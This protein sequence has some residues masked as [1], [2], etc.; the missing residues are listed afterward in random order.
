MAVRITKCVK[1]KSSNIIV[2]NPELRSQVKKY[3]C[4]LTCKCNEC[5]VEFKIK[6]WTIYGKKKGVRY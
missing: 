4:E 2:L 1:C 5:E 6:S 3:M